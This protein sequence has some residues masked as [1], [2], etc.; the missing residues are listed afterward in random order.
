M[1]LEHEM[2]FAKVSNEKLRKLKFFLLVTYNSVE[3][4][5]LKKFDWIFFNFLM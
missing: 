5:F 1:A 2:N 3:L 4:M